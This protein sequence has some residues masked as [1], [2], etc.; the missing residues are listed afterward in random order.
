M[1]TIGLSRSANTIKRE[2]VIFIFIDYFTFTCPCILIIHCQIQ[3]SSN[4]PLFSFVRRR[5]KGG[6]VISIE[7]KLP[8]EKMR[9]IN[10]RHRPS[11]ESSPRPRVPYIPGKLAKVQIDSFPGR[12]SVIGRL[13]FSRSLEIFELCYSCLVLLYG[14][15]APAISDVIV[16]TAGA[17]NSARRRKEGIR[18]SG[19]KKVL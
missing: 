3:R 6:S 11:T 5:K 4:F 15:D 1:S 14:R 12:R 17:G 13:N 8:V 19:K 9:K 16:G 7:T 18:P 2:A 10:S